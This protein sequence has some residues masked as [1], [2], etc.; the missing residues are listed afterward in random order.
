MAYFERHHE[1]SDCFDVFNRSRKYSPCKPRVYNSIKLLRGNRA[2]ADWCSTDECLSKLR[3]SSS[4]IRSH[5][6]SCALHSAWPGEEC[7][8]YWQS[9]LRLFDCSNLSNV[10]WMSIDGALLWV[11]SVSLYFCASHDCALLFYFLT[12]GVW[13]GSL[14]ALLYFLDSFCGWFASHPMLLSSFILLFVSIYS[15]FSH[16]NLSLVKKSS[17]SHSSRHSTFAIRASQR[18][19]HFHQDR[20]SNTNRV[21]HIFLCWEL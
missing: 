1:G 5:F 2:G 11:S 20:I 7:T 3:V 10:S 13:I 6:W 19:G 17:Q 8:G 16:C 12:A 14:L 21:Y 9:K 15:K 4:N 18:D